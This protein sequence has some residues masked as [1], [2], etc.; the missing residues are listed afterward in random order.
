MYTLAVF[1]LIYIALRLSWPR[2]S[3]RHEFHSIQ[4][5]HALCLNNMTSNAT[6]QFPHL[7]N[8]DLSGYVRKVQFS[9]NM[10]YLKEIL[11]EATI[12]NWKK[13]FNNTQLCIRKIWDTFHKPNI[14][15]VH[16]H[17]HAPIL[18]LWF[19]SVLKIQGNVI[20][21][22]K[23]S[24]GKV[25]FSQ[26]SVCPWGGVSLVISNPSCDIL[27]GSLSPRDIRPWDLVPPTLDIRPGD[28]TL[29]QSPC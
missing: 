6:S 19:D 18:S 21:A 26:A 20:T 28:L 16:T 23:R 13:R 17:S 3:E 11:K 29:T 5:C 25:M 15:Q 8:F 4:R 1:T 12:F 27:P 2:S 7:T 22:R 9:S 24:Y 10:F 14:F